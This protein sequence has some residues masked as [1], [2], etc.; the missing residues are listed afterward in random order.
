LGGTQDCINRRNTDVPLGGTQ[1]QMGIFLDVPWGRTEDFKGLIFWNQNRDTAIC[2]RMAVPQNE[3]G[4]FFDFN[5]LPWQR[6]LTNGKINYC[7]IIGMYSAFIWWKDCENRSSTSGDIR[8][9]TLFRLTC[10]P[11]KLLDQSSP[12]FT[13]YSGISGAI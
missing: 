5:W 12:N 9:N 6:P 1:D 4:R 7:S 3:I 11:P 13:R 10:F 8:R 2:C